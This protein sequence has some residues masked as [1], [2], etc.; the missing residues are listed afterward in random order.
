MNRY[1]ATCPLPFEELLRL[2]WV[3]VLGGATVGFLVARFIKASGP[4]DGA[5]RSSAP[6]TQAALPAASS[7]VSQRSQFDVQSGQ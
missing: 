1:F 5:A 4:G 3:A 7:P 6:S 2:K